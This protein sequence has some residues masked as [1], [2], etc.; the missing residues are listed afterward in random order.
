MQ[1]ADRLYCSMQ[2]MLHLESGHPLALWKLVGLLNDQLRFLSSCLKDCN[3]LDPGA[4]PDM[5]LRDLI[6]G[7]GLLENATGSTSS[8][9]D[10]ER[11][12]ATLRIIRGRRGSGIE[13]AGAGGGNL[14]SRRDGN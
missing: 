6:L 13:G 14:S 3:G 8:C 11:M 10:S 2:R 4:E 9:F 7:T 5:N 1:K 12:L